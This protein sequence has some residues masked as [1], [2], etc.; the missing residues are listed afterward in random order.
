MIVGFRHKGVERFY[1]TGRTSEINAR[2]ADKLPRLVT[3]LDVIAEP[4]DMRLPGARLHELRG[5]RTG[6]WAV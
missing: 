3:T 1:K 6:Q 4:D 5:N 2:H